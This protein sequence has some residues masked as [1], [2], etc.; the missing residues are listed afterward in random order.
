VLYKD[1]K[2]KDADILF[3]PICASSPDWA[4]MWA[5]LEKIGL[6]RIKGEAGNWCIKASY[7]DKPVD[8]FFAAD[9]DDGSY[10][11]EQDDDDL[12]LAELFKG[13]DPGK[14]LL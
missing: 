3:Y 14:D 5:A 2:R 10:G 4:G 1:G 11:I 8:C 6:H 13:E 7:Q 12:L 9:G